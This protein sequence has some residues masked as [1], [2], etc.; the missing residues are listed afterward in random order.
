MDWTFTEVIESGRE[1]AQG[2]G[3]PEEGEV[4]EWVYAWY[5]LR[6]LHQAL[7]S[8]QEEGFMVV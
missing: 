4:R 3:V 2:R 8:S 1:R 7:S 6:H 5:H